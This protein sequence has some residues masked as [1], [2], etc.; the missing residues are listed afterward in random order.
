M[1][2]NKQCERSPK[3]L[4]AKNI[5]NSIY[6]TLEKLELSDEAYECYSKAIDGH[7]SEKIVEIKQD[8][9]SKRGV[10]AHIQKE[11][12]DRA[13]S[14]GTLSESSP[15]YA[16]NMKRLEELADQQRGL[17][18][19]IRKLQEKVVTPSKIKLSK[20]EFL[21]LRVDNEKVASYLWREPFATLVRATEIQSGG[22]GWT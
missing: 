21:N 14:L 15:A 2:H 11:A 3:S 19:D 4:R 8:L 9:H 22:D 13:L 10:L 20:E 6:A 12:N 5:F 17:E 1:S 18:D 7:T 16:P